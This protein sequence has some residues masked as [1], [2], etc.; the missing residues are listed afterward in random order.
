MPVA[1][2]GVN[3]GMSGQPAETQPYPSPAREILS[4][5]SP[6]HWIPDPLYMPFLLVAAACHYT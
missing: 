1:P 6:C 4:P 5:Y 3:A 2:T